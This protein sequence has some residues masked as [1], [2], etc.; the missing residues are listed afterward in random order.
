[1]KAE[2][3][4]KKAEVAGFTLIETIVALTLI[5]AAVSGPMALATRG[6]FSAKFAKSRLVALNLSQEGIELIRHMREN[7]VLAGHDWR[8]LSGAC[9]STC[10]RLQDGPY[11]PDVFTAAS[12]STPPINAGA[13]LR[14]DEATGLYSQSTGLPTPFT[15]VVELSTPA[16]NQMRVLS[17]VTWMESGIPRSSRVE[18]VFYN[19]R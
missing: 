16:A 11:Q 13:I 19:W 14:Y 9:P 1:M 4:R 18:E 2:G 7:N 10:S 17:T 3:K 12:G 5:V 15:R 8:G 6:I